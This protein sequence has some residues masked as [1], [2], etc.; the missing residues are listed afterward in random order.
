[1]SEDETYIGEDR[2][3]ETDQQSLLSAAEGLRIGMAELGTKFE[4]VDTYSRETRQI[5]ADTS[6]ASRKVK[7]VMGALV[8]VV[9]LLVVLFAR[10]DRNLDKANE[11]LAQVQE[12]NSV[13]EQN[14]RSRVAA[15]VLGNEER[16]NSKALFESILALE[17]SSAAEQNY[18]LTA[19]DRKEMKGYTK[20]VNRAY[21][22]R[23]CAA[24]AAEPEAAREASRADLPSSSPEESP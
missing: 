3:R 12:V 19:A 13:V 7:M 4:V 9:G 8:L 2:R 15:C 16:L 5:A 11:A 14:I 6:A 23:D 10:T 24:I 22:P 21:K 17:V 1:M 20:L 18:E